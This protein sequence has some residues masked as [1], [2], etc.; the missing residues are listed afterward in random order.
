M[1]ESGMIPDALRDVCKKEAP[2]ALYLVPTIHNPTS[3]VVPEGR[4]RELATIAEENDLLVIEDEILR[5]LVPDPPPPVS[6]FIPE[7]SFFIASMSKSVAGGLRMAYLTVPPA[8]KQK[9]S[10]VVGSSIF[11]VAPLSVE[12][13]TLWIEDGTARRT[14]ERKRQEA[15]VRQ[16]MAG[17]IL[18]NHRYSAH[19]QSYYVWLELPEAW[20]SAEFAVEAR[21][22]GVGVTPSGPFTVASSQQRH[23]ARLCLSAAEDRSR[24][25]TALRTLSCMLSE[26]GIGTSGIV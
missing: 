12:I 3:I 14:V 9:V 2:R 17:E 22:K 11:M 16:S 24:L 6:S 5:L 8:F 4:R 10:F 25:D 15:E 23:A 7:R 21:R 1:D 20:N 19:P 26:P 13:A 18:K